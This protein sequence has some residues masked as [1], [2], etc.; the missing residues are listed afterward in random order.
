ML[1]LPADQISRRDH[2]FD[3][4]GTSLSA[5]RPAIAMDRA[6]FLEDLTHHP[7][8]ADLAVL[9]DDRLET[10]PGVPCV[11]ESVAPS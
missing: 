4:G 9:V 5:V 8:L 1:G 3:L 2:F 11:T 7:V 6:V 10:A